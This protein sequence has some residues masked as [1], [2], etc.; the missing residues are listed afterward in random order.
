VARLLVPFILLLAIVGASV[1]TDRPL[2]RADFT[3]INRGDTTTLDTQR[4]SWM[5]DLR[6]AKLL[7]EGLV[8]HDVFTWDYAIRPGVA[9][10]WTVSEDRKTYTFHIR[11]SA[12]WSNGD[13]VRA[14]DFV[15]S[16]RRALLPETAADYTGMFQ[17]IRGGKAFF[18]WRIAA[19]KGFDPARDDAAG[20]W[21]RSLEEFDRVVGLRAPDEST[22]VIELESPVPYFLDLCAFSV[23]APV[24]PPLVSQFERPDARTGRIVSRRDWTKPPLAVTNGPFTLKR[25][26]YKRDMRLEKNP[27]WWNAASVA[28]DT[29]DIPSMEDANAQVLAFQTGAVDWVSDVSA[30]FKGDML[31]DKWRFYREHQAR[32]EALK[33]QGL[34]QFEIDRRLPPDPRKNIHAVPTFGTYWYNF[35]C[36]PKLQDGRA[37][38]FA[39]ARVRRAFT[40]AI[41]KQTLIDT[42]VRTGNPVANTII[43]PGSI[44]GY[45]SPGGVLYDPPA[46]RKLLTEA[47]YEDGAAF[48]ITVEILFNKDGGHDK[49]AEFIG[50]GWERELGVRVALVQKE[51]KVVK[52]DLQNANYMV[53]RAGWYGDYGDPTTF[54]DLSRS[55][56]GN[57]DRKYNNPAYDRL[58]EDAAKESDPGARMRLLEEAERLLMDEE[59]PMAPIYQYVTLY[60][61]D[62]ERLS[63]INPH[64]RTEQHLY[65]I[66]IFGDGKGPD[67]SRHM[68]ARAASGTGR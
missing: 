33:A 40:M 41:D 30:P 22:L 37:N 62:A 11:D 63:G 52:D 59:L 58:L 35:N 2:P 20:L 27:L 16:W 9:D 26:R 50:K 48:P 51:I 19:L 54:L 13:R 44:P 56:D 24:Y 28:I 36:R 57:N 43:P 61:F 12:R 10:R 39:D 15:Y 14:G 7:S 42:V 21:R 65:L 32:Y 64:P 68:P 53:S 67:V 5:Q 23:F 8:A 60:L 17:L 49:I 45:R 1:L 18:D 3:F 66:D 38:P 25:W 46:A 29:I 47:G 55:W 4:M 6:M 31:A 34:D